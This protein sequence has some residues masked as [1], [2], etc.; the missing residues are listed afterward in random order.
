MALRLVYITHENRRK[1]KALARRLVEE[2][3]VACVNII[4]QTEAIYWWKGKVAE[5]PEAALLCKTTPKN[6]PK[7]IKRVRQ[8]HTYEIPCVLVLKV[9]T[10]NKEYIEWL[11]KE[12]R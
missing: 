6:V 3:L 10:G 9:E 2:R 4:P 11:C 8:L 12:C 1:A 7:L 5:C